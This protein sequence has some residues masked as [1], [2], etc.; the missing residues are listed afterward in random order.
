EHFAFDAWRTLSNPALDWSWWRAD[1]WQVEQSNRVLRFL[2]S[3][4]ENVPDL[5]R[6]DGTPLVADS[7]NAPGLLAMA[8]T[9]ALAADREI[10]EPWVRKLWDLPM[11]PGRYRYYNGLLTMLALLEVSGN[12]R[13]YEAPSPA[14]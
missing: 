11:P 13:A 12:F 7:V 6:L 8:A 2:A 4:G 9:A 1:P 3:H 14:P 10:G 5:Y